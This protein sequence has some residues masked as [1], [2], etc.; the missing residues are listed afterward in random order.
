[1]KFDWHNR[2]LIA[3]AAA[4]LISG[5][6]VGSLTSQAMSGHSGP[7]AAA[8]VSDELNGPATGLF[9]HPRDK[10]APRAGDV[11]PDG[12]AVWKQRLDTSGNS[13]K[14]CVTFSKPLDPS[15]P[16][17]D[18]VTVTPALATAPAVSANGS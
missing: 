8:A 16:Y 11:K 3:S 5:F 9:G 15:K 7:R 1:M 4:V 10:N 6:C 13:P 14:A 18:Y 17:G 12:F 2:T